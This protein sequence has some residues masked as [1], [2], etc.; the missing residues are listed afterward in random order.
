MKKSWIFAGLG[1]VAVVAVGVFVLTTK[2]T[3]DTKRGD[4]SATGNAE[5]EKQTK[6]DY[7]VNFVPSSAAGGEKEWLA[8]YAEENLRGQSRNIVK[9][10]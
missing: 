4:D 9:I 5:T 1:V 10:C 8:G 6:V 2:N 3:N 7:S